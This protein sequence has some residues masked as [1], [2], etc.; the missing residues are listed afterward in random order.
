M[1]KAALGGR[2]R[3]FSLPTPTWH[4]KLFSAE[5]T[6]AQWRSCNWEL[7]SLLRSPLVLGGW[8]LGLC[9]REGP[10]VCLGV[11][12]V[13]GAELG[14]SWLLLQGALAVEVRAKD[15]E[16]LDMV[17]VLHD[18]E[19]V[20]RC[21]AERA[22]MKHLVGFAWEEQSSR[23]QEVATLSTAGVFLRVAHY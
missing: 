22:F 12:A 16:I 15:Q 23:L 14:A 11:R 17:S 1:T 18:R 13:G 3:S 8:M 5:E 2:S 19:T 4:G 20:L 6:F 10:G 21:I 7:H 9:L